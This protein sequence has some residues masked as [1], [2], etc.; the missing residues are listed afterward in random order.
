MHIW[1]LAC[2]CMLKSLWW[3]SIILT[4]AVTRHCD[5]SSR[6][7]W[8]PRY[9]KPGSRGMM[10]GPSKS[11]CR[12]RE[13]MIYVAT[14]ASSLRHQ[15][16]AIHIPTAEPRYFRLYPTLSARSMVARN[17]TATRYRP[18]KSFI[19]DPNCISTFLI[20]VRRLRRQEPRSRELRAVTCFIIQRFDFKPKEGFRM[21]S[22]EEGIEDYF[23][24]KRPALPVV[25]EVRRWL[26][27]S[28]DTILPVLTSENRFGTSLRLIQ[29]D[30]SSVA[31][32][33]ITPFFVTYPLALTR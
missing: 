27:R 2:E 32:L 1:T 18:T 8:P 26:L 10:V 31:N 21:E 6:Y 4:F 20:Q 22:W 30:I 25:V 9:V 12:D 3:C 5:S 11:F 28:V 16:L 23:V 13:V 24:A 14:L 19:L 7:E 17:K 29:Y 15:V 33:K